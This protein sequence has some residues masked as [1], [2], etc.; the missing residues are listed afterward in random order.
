MY[1]DCVTLK[2]CNKAHQLHALYLRTII[3]NYKSPTKTVD[4][5]L[6]L[7]E[8]VR[9]K[10]KDNTSLYITVREVMPSLKYQR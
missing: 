3:A 1:N 2:H 4:V 6:S 7:T 9:S 5:E 10:K 8:N